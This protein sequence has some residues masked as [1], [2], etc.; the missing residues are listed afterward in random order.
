MGSKPRSPHCKHSQL[1]VGGNEDPATAPPTSAQ[2]LQES[3]YLALSQTQCWQEPW[4]AYGLAQAAP[5]SSAGLQ[6]CPIPGWVPT[7]LRCQHSP[8]QAPWISL[9]P[10]TSPVPCCSWGHPWPRLN[11]SH[12]PGLSTEELLAGA[13][14][15]CRRGERKGSGSC[16]WPTDTDNLNVT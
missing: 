15:F 5:L 9:I 4:N 11:P 10:C 7:L 14:I 1:L 8:G 16:W 12:H 6:P 3:Q 13:S 2:N